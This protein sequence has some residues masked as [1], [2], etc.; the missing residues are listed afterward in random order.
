MAQDRSRA[1]VK[2]RQQYNLFNKGIHLI[3]GLTELA[4]HSPDKSRHHTAHS[5]SVALLNS[6]NLFQEPGLCT[7]EHFTST[8]FEYTGYWRNC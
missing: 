4:L 2:H 3:A 6:S 7:R 1:D 8:P 5:E